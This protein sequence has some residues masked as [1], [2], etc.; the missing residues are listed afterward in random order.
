MIYLILGLLT[1]SLYAI[2]MGPTTLESPKAAMSPDT[3]H[4]GF[5]LMGAVILFG[6][7]KLKVFTEE[8]GD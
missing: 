1:G 4:L 2:V 5:F 8:K 6:L 7:E 3:F